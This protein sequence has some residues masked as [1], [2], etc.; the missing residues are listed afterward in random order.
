[1]NKTEILGYLEANGISDVEILLE[2]PNVLVVSG[3]FDF[4]PAEIDAAVA[5]ATEQKEDDDGPELYSDNLT[6]YLVDVAADNVGELLE[7]IMED[8]DVDAQY[9]TYSIDVEDHSFVPLAILFSKGDIE[10]NLE[11]ILEDLDL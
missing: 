3:Y 9:V 4:D 6:S 5:Y 1:M 7:G 2:E 8:E 10:R 11:D